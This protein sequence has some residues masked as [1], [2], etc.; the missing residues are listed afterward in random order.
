MGLCSPFPKVLFTPS[1][2]RVP[3]N[4]LKKCCF[5]SEN[6]QKVLFFQ[7]SIAMIHVPVWTQAEKWIRTLPLMGPRKAK[8]EVK[9]KNPTFY[10]IV[11]KL[12]QLVAPKKAACQLPRPIEHS[13]TA[14]ACMSKQ[15]LALFQLKKLKKGDIHQ[16]RHKGRKKRAFPKR[17]KGRKNERAPL[18]KG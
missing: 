1:A 7:W 14:I 15:I 13:E 18:G 17:P 11:Y 6:R 9:F 16:N 4:M 2:F 10:S 5:F 3:Q 12:H 8:Q